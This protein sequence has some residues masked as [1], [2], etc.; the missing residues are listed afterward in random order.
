MARRSRGHATGSLRPGTGTRHPG[1]LAALR[2][3]PTWTRAAM[4]TPNEPSR[5]RCGPRHARHVQTRVTSTKRTPGVRGQGA[6]IDALG[7]PGQR[8]VI[9]ATL[10]NRNSGGQAAVV[11]LWADPGAMGGHNVT[12]TATAT[13]TAGQYA[14]PV[15]PTR[16][17][18]VVLLLGSLIA[19]GPLSIDLYLPALP[20]LT[21]DL[22]ESV[23]RPADADRNPRRARAQLVIGPLTDIYGR[24]RRSS[25]LPSTS[26]PRFSARSRRP[27]WSSTS[28]ACCRASA[29]QRR[30]SWQWPSCGTCSPDGLLRPSSPG[31]SW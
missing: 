17:W 21:E 29:R 12:A 28:C 25:G 4:A 15:A 3:R 11:D 13:T 5:A 30:A 2:P 16:P 18:R 24:R 9:L 20:D 8:K 26:S 1:P 10:R 23:L 31:S 19:L 22:P 14:E 27:S 7:R 6:P